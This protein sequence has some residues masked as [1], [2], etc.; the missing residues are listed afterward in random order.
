MIPGLG[1]AF[2][3]KYTNQGNPS[4]TAYGTSV[5]PG[6]SNAE[7]S[8]QQ[9]ASAANIANEVYAL[10]LR[11]TG[12]NT[13]GTQKDHLLDI[14]IDPAGG[15]SY[16]PIVS[17]LLCG[18]SDASSQDG[19][20]FV[21]PLRIPEGASVAVRIQGSNATAGT[22]IVRAVFYGRPTR[23]DAVRAGAYSETI[24]TISGSAGVGVTPGSTNAEGSW[25]SLG[26]TAKDLWWWQLCVQISNGTTTNKLYHFDL[27]YGDVTN[28][29]M[30]LENLFWATPGTAERVIFNG[31]L[32]NF[33]EAFRHVP[34]GSEIFVR[35]TCNTTPDTGLT[36]LAVGVGG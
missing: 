34:A 29:V 7:G 9:I 22:V 30:I 14:G 21:L 13:T 10:T 25:V 3:W 23:P 19:I 35:A 5:T 36:A 11:V 16:T 6:A 18:Q 27:A 24:G 4:T 1:C 2:N 28:K 33:P 20:T 15:T 31:N 32:I 26:T 12:G 17:N 8:W